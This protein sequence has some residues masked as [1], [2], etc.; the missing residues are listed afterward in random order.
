MFGKQ[1]PSHLE[2]FAKKHNLKIIT[3][4]DLI[5]YR[6]RTQELMKIEVVANMPTDNGTFKI[7]GFENHIDG[8]E[9]IALVKGDVPE[10]TARTRVH[11]GDE[12]EFGGIDGLARRAG[13]VDFAVFQRFAQNFQNFAVKLGQLVQK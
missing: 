3:I 11:G 1:T 7:V 12:L 13:N 4:A 2:I 9:H 8:K 10:I 6:K 5:K